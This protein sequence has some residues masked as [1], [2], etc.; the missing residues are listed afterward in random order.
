MTAIVGTHGRSW[1]R[2]PGPCPAGG[3]TRS[4]V[5]TVP[6]TRS[7]PPRFAAAGRSTTPAGSLVT[8]YRTRSSDSPDSSAAVAVPPVVVVSGVVVA[9]GDD[10]GEVVFDVE[11]AVGDEL[12]EV[13]ADDVA[14]FFTDL[15]A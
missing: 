2:R 6:M 11:V 5:T 4:S 10:G 8:S 7:R 3:S 12:G 1:W 9:D 14:Q 13:D 15:P